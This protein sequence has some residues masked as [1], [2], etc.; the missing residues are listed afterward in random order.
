MKQEDLHNII[1]KQ[2]KTLLA[3]HLP[4]Y[5]REDTTRPNSLPIDAIMVGPGP[6]QKVTEVSVYALLAQKSYDV[7]VWLSE[8]PFRVP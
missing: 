8:V 6:A 7:Q 1:F 3:R 5:L 2:K 4:V